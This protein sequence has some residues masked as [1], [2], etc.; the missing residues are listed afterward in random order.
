M[1][2]KIANASLARQ[3]IATNTRTPIINQVRNWF[4]KSQTKIYTKP[5]R[6]MSK[7]ENVFWFV[8]FC[9]T[10]LSVPIW[11]VKNYGGG[12]KSD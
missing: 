6:T 10:M 2:S 9:S 12:I 11:V 5:L 3:L 1:I 8:F 7:A 4:P